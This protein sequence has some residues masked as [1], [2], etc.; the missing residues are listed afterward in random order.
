MK[1]IVI[2]LISAIIISSCA[3]TKKQMQRGNYD[4]VIS[5]CVKKLVKKPDSQEHSSMLDKAYKLANDQDLER[6]KYLKT[7]NNPDNWDEIFNRY[8]NLK[9]RQSLVRTVLPLKLG[10]RSINYEYIDYDA[11]I[12]RA[13]KNA[14]EYYY[15]NGKQLL[16]NKDKES[17]R[18]AYY[19]LTRAQQYAGSSYPD[20]NDLIN[21]ARLMGISK[22]LVK[23]ENSSRI[24]ISPDFQDQLLSFS[25]QDLNSE[26]VEYQL[27]N[28][29]KDADFDYVAVVHLID[30]VVSPEDTRNIDRI[31]KKDVQDGF[32]YAKDSRGNVMKDTAGND[33]KIPKY[34]TL[35][36]TLIETS[37]RKAVNIRGE[38]EITQLKPTRKLLVKEP[39][40]AENVFANSS[41]RAVGD[42]AALDD[43]ARQKVKNPLVPYPSDIQMIYNTS[44]TLKPAIRNAIANNRRY[45][46]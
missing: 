45:I 11:E 17:Y 16:Q 15:T 43:E 21:K 34:K 30:I 1:R 5:K 27:R 25:A 10:G 2:F 13:K 18:N 41:A 7:E 35:Q 37:Q 12:V 23:V 24:M 32:E 8:A 31:Y 3:G 36:C 29:G 38:V 42:N 6:I 22:V 40:G 44:E 26:W 33:I 4:I 28:F 19:Q 39:I 14:A 9:D 46:Y 20:L